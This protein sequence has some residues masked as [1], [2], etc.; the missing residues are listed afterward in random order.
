MAVGES[1]WCK[2]SRRFSNE[3]LKQLALKTMGDA[4][5]GSPVDAIERASLGRAV[6]KL[7]R[8]SELQFQAKELTLRT[9]D[10]SMT[11]V[12]RK[13]FEGEADALTACQIQERMTLRGFDTRRYTNSI[14]AIHNAAQRLAERGELE[15]VRYPHRGS[16]YRART[17]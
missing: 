12:L 10:Q 9:S 1:I 6:G 15:R 5:T 2:M 17:K 3:R 14:A 4:R 7:M 8:N 16:A 13:I 11:R